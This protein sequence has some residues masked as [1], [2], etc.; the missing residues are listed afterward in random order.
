MFKEMPVSAHRMS[1]SYSEKGGGRERQTDRKTWGKRKA[2]K[3][4]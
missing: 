3:R 4:R 2:P 1:Q